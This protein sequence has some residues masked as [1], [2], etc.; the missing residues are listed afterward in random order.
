T[1]PALA[2]LLGSQVDAFFDNIAS[3]YPH[4]KAGA[5]KILAVTGAERSP[6]AP[7]LPTLAESGLPGFEAVTWFA[8]AAPPGTP[9]DIVA[10]L[11]AGI[12]E[13]LKLPDVKRK[14]TEQGAQV[15]GGTPAETAAFFKS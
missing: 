7:E 6:L 11:N 3:S 2:D 4:H 15:V 8:V 10:K 14:F 5:G 1:A 13:A 9:A 12:V